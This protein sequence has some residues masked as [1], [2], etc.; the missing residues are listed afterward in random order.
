MT[1]TGFEL[2]PH[3][4]S[5]GFLTVLSVFLIFIGGCTGSTSGGIKVF[6]FQ[7][8]YRVMRSQIYQLLHPHGVFIPI[9]NQ[10]RVEDQVVLTILA[11]LALYLLCY[12][13]LAL[14]FA[15]IGLDPETSLLTTASILTNTGIGFGPDTLEAI[16]FPTSA[17]WLMILGMLLGRL[18]FIALIVVVTLPFWRR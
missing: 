18:E 4:K 8:L 10:R 3:T 16:S 17:K 1:T 12:A 6:R 11:F 2:E 15:F 14:S 5:K 13:L 7:I 9:Y